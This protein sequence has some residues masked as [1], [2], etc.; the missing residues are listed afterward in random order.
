VRFSSE[1]GKFKLVQQRQQAHIH[2][3]R[4]LGR[5][6]LNRITANSLLC[7]ER[8]FSL[9]FPACKRL[10]SSISSNCEG[11]AAEN[12]PA[13]ACRQHLLR[14][15]VE[16]ESLSIQPEG[17]ATRHGKEHHRLH[18]ILALGNPHSI[19]VRHCYGQRRQI[20]EMGFLYGFL[21]Q[22]NVL[23]TLFLPKKFPFRR[24]FSL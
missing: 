23:I 7:L 21:G 11:A 18:I 20:L 3:V 12:S 1:A 24:F 13:A 15:G 22:R 14:S 10:V 8:T 19:N 2:S 16:G 6:C 17:Y 5:H 4:A 9:S